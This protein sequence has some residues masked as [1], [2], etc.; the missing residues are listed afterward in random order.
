[1]T[2]RFILYDVETGAEILERM[3]VEHMYAFIVG[4]GLLKGE[5]KGKHYRIVSQVSGYA[6]DVDMNTTQEEIRK[7]SVSCQMAI[8]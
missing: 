1:M 4:N 3:Q 6:I 8:D 7:Y 2:D 5:N